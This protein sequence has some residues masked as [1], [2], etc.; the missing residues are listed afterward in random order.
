[1]YYTLKPLIHPSLYS[2]TTDK[3]WPRNSTFVYKFGSNV[4]GY[5]SNILWDLCPFR[6]NLALRFYYTSPTQHLDLSS[7]SASEV[8]LKTLKKVESKGGT[9]YKTITPLKR[10]NNYAK[11]STAARWV[12]VPGLSYRAASYIYWYL[13]V[14]ICCKRLFHALATQWLLEKWN[15]WWRNL[16][17]CGTIW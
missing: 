14:P 10:S 12:C 4:L 7:Q 5:I 6:G 1:M 15:K 11:V 8:Q 2:N 16:G 13:A 9:S 3:V 17:F